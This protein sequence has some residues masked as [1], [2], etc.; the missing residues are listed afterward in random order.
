[1]H[2]IC[3]IKLSL[4]LSTNKNVYYNNKMYIRI[5]WS[6][7][8]I[9]NKSIFVTYNTKSNARKCTEYS[10]TLHILKKYYGNK[11]GGDFIKCREEVMYNFTNVYY[12][13]LTIKSNKRIL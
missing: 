13:T 10:N 12:S 4:T 9:K 6:S 5:I 2:R 7:F 1:M 11:N 3:K 8:I